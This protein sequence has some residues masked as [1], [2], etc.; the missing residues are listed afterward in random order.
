MDNEV[1]METG[2]RVDL[3]FPNI[4]SFLWSDWLGRIFGIFSFN[5][6]SVGRG[7]VIHF[8]CMHPGEILVMTSDCVA[9]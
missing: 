8:G 5:F 6:R 4:F 9:H 1:E 3:F 7:F 2:A